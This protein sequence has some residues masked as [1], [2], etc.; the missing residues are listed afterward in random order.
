MAGVFGWGT[1]T[2]METHVFESEDATRGFVDKFTAEVSRG[3]GGNRATVLALSGDL[4]TGKTF[5]VK[6]LAANLNV[7]ETITS[8]TFVLARF[9]DLAEN[10]PW[11]RLIHIDAYRLEKA[12]DLIKLGWDDWVSDP[13][14]LVCI[15]WPEQIFAD[16][17]LKDFTRLYFGWVNETT[18]Q[19]RV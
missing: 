5:F 8:P 19:I 10:L 17:Q 13:A 16:E 1:V 4:G 18:R 9:Y 2:D 15:E 12:D 3:A 7:T 6:S 14:N 11:Q